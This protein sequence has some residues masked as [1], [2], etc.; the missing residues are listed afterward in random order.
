[1][2]SWHPEK[3]WG[4]IDSP[5]TPGGCW[6]HISSVLHDGPRDLT[7]GQLV[8]FDYE[9]AEQDGYRFRAVEV[10]LAGDQPDAG[11]SE[12]QDSSEAYR[13]S[14]TITYDEPPNRGPV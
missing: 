14:L 3:G 8:L 2:R 4:V 9:V 10:R 11:I 5:D 12:I 1:M 6:A 7:A 13:S